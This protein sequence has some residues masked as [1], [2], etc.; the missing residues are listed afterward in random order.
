[1]KVE[2]SKEV[3]EAIIKISDRYYFDLFKQIRVSEDEEYQFRDAIIE[4][5]KQ[6][7]ES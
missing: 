3:A 6:I 5:A 1:M 2:I 4:L 7:K